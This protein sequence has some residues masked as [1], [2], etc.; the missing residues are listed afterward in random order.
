MLLNKGNL[1]LKESSKAIVEN[2]LHLN[3]SRNG[4]GKYGDAP[5]LRSE[6]FSAEQMKQHG[7][8]LAGLHKLS[9][10]RAPDQLLPRLAENEDVLLGVHAL[11]IEAVA[12]NRQITPAGEWLLDNFY[13]IEE[14]IRTAKRH[15]PKAYSRELPRLREGP[16]IGLPR[17][18]DIA[19]EVIS[20]GDGRV[21]P[22]SLTSFVAAYQTV[23][24]LTLGELWAL[25]I[26][27]RLALIENL[28]R[29]SARI[30][31]DRIG[32]NRADEW[33]DQL[34]ETAEKDPKNLIV[35]IA[36]LARSN[37]PMESSFVAEVTRRLQGQ[38]P[39]LTLPLTWIEQLLSESGWTIQQMVQSENQKQAA[40]QVSMS[41]S[42]GSLRY[43]SALDWRKFVESMSEV[44]QILREDSGAVYARMEFG[45][46]D[47]YRHVVERIA[48][49][50]GHN[51]SDVALKAI[52]LAKE[53]A[54]SN[55][56]A[57]RTAHVGDYLV[58]EGLEQLEQAVAARLPAGERVGRACRRSPV[59]LY[60]GGIVLITLALAGLLTLEAHGSTGNIWVLCL[61]GI[62]WMVAV[63]QLAVAVV[64]WLVTLVVTPHTLPRMDFSAGI[65]P[66][67]RTLVVVPSMLLNPD[68]VQELVEKLEVRF[69]ANR[70]ENV[71]F[72][73]L[74]DF[75]DANEEVQPEDESLLDL[76]V[77]GIA[78]LNARYEPGTG[79]R[80]FLFHRPRRWN[81]QERLWMGYER[82]RGKL[83]DL[84]ALLR[85]A[86]PDAFSRIVGETAK[87]TDVKYVITLDTDTQLPRDSARQLVGAAAHPLN[88]AHLL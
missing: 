24:P 70:D 6:L 14:Q 2:L 42:I 65:P 28:R 5:P 77:Q 15:L 84:N 68:N 79:A 27:L 40:N 58:G 37:P 29:V 67:Y 23:T 62:L 47:S 81:P 46:R 21:D 87:L 76:A 55:G 36:D 41:N 10:G 74:T 53:G 52:D 72:A 44:E 39:S 33:A 35:V 8:R 56:S 61:I 83:G 18:Y 75:R 48:K 50:S 86:A 34:I 69:L 16:S 66:E 38:G 17:V 82:K 26:M 1:K 59:L 54:A 43:L 7:R 64:N 71:H 57:D 45:T 32:R 4:S 51:E 11:M 22:E 60:V 12:A 9:P 49:Y 85:G 63:S 20:H 78:D 25:P 73:L 19:L 31:D 88:R 30:A 3:L 80:F 13:L